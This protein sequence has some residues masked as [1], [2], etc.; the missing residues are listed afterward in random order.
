MGRQRPI[1]RAQTSACT[2]GSLR[3]PRESDPVRPLQRTATA[4]RSVE[5]EDAGDGFAVDAIGPWRQGSRSGPTGGMSGLTLGFTNRLARVFRAETRS[6]YAKNTTP[7]TVER[8][9]YRGFQIPLGSK[10]NC[11]PCSIGLNS[12][13]WTLMARTNASVV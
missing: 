4:G 8:C 12:R 3:R 13:A 7:V 11:L 2:G 10:R 5:P 1:Q 6:V 9:R